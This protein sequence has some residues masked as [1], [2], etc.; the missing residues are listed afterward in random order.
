MLSVARHGQLHWQNHPAIGFRRSRAQNTENM[1][2]VFQKLFILFYFK[3]Q[4]ISVFGMLLEQE[5][6][7]SSFAAKSVEMS[8][9]L[10][11]SVYLPWTLTLQVLACM[12]QLLHLLRAEGLHASKANRQQEAHVLR[13]ALS[14]LGSNCCDDVPQVSAIGNDQISGLEL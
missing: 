3:F 1:V 13:K 10:T 12:P 5:Q 6:V 9:T 11:S 7:T 2:A 14:A 4:P 8:Q